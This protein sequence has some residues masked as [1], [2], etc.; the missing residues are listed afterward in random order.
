MKLIKISHDPNS[1]SPLANSYLK[2]HPHFRELAAY[3]VK[4]RDKEW[5][6]K[7]WV[8]DQRDCI[9]APF[10]S[11][12]IVQHLGQCLAHNRH[13]LHSFTIYT[14]TCRVPG[15]LSKA[16]G[17]NVTTLKEFKIEWIWGPLLSLLNSLDIPFEA[18]IISL[19]WV[20]RKSN[21]REAPW[22]A[23]SPVAP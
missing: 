13:A 19:P 23:P 7:T 22:P 8:Y 16:S 11:E 21:F 2:T 5:T 20:I 3:V 18:E 12:I 9:R 4:K 6:W 14:V 15:L 1:T 10:F 17:G